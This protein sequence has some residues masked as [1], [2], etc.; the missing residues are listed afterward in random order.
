MKS[1]SHHHQPQD[2]AGPLPGGSRYPKAD[3]PLV[4][5]IEDASGAREALPVRKAPASELSRTPGHPVRLPWVWGRIAFIPLTKGYIAEINADDLGLVQG[6][7][8][9][10]G[11]EKRADGSVYTAYAYGKLKGGKRVALHRLLMGFPEGKTVDHRDGNGLNNRRKNLRIASV[12][13]NAF[14]RR[15]ARNNTSGV[16]G[17]TFD[18]SKGK[19][20]AMIRVGG[21]LIHLGTFSSKEDAARKIVDERPVIHGE[22][23]RQ[24]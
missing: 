4:C 1:F 21:R 20:R 22:F 11:E 23:G 24:E 8:W 16:K 14:N 3:L 2:A 18:K 13:E 6:I 5:Q 17:V 7:S 9:H 15:V 12:A 10:A 19:W